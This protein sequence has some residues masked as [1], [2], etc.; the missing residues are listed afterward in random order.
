MT[1]SYIR[2]TDIG[3]HNVLMNIPGLKKSKSTIFF[4]ESA[5]AKIHAK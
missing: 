3:N 4:R 2:V 5:G 1:V